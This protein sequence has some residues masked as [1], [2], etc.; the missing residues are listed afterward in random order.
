MIPSGLES[1]LLQG[2]GDHASFS[3]TGSPLYRI[4]VERG[5]Q[6]VIYNLQY[7]GFC[8]ALNFDTPDEARARSVHNVILRHKNGTQSWVVRDGLTRSQ[9]GLTTFNDVTGSHDLKCYAMITGDAFLQVTTMPSPNNWTIFKLSVLTGG[10]FYP[11]PPQGYG[12][13]LGV[14]FQTAL[15]K[16]SNVLSPNDAFGCHR[17]FAPGLASSISLY[18]HVPV[19]ALTT[20]NDPVSSPEGAQSYPIIN[21]SGVLLNTEEGHKYAQTSG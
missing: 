3:L 16:P 19:D 18:G 11:P 13:G 10:G 21:V 15:I 1:L 5:K 7:F 8:D 6:L 2:V 14:P 4:V 17:F 9:S 20:L 12:Q